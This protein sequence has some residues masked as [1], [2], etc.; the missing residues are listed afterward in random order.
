MEAA[1]PS[2][3]ANP[4]TLMA[5]LTVDQMKTL[6]EQWEEIA[7]RRDVRRWRAAHGAAIAAAT[8]GARHFQNYPAG[9]AAESTLAEHGDGEGDHSNSG[10][11]VPNPH[12]A[13]APAP[14]KSTSSPTA[15]GV[16]ADRSPSLRTDQKTVSG[17]HL[18]SLMSFRAL[19]RLDPGPESPFALRTASYGEGGNSTGDR[20]KVF[21]SSFRIPRSTFLRLLAPPLRERFSES[22]LPLAKLRQMLRA[23]FRT[24][25]AESCGQI[26]WDTL[27][28]YL[29]DTEAAAGI[30]SGKETTVSSAVL[31]RRRR[32]GSDG[33]I[34][35][36]G[37]PKKKDGIFD[38][39]SDESGESS[40]AS[41]GA[42]TSDDDEDEEEDEDDEDAALTPSAVLAV[43]EVKW[44]NSSKRSTINFLGGNLDY[45]GKLIALDPNPLVVAVTRL[46]SLYFLDTTDSKFTALKS[47]KLPGPP[48]AWVYVHN[49]AMAMSVPGLFAVRSFFVITT[50]NL[51]MCLFP[52]FGLDSTD[53]G[54]KLRTVVQNHELVSALEWGRHDNLLYGGTRSGDLLVWN[55]TPKGAIIP[56]RRFGLHSD[57]ITKL[58]CTTGY[59][60]ISCS[61][62]QTIQE[63]SLGRIPQLAT[64][65]QSSTIKGST[66]DGSTGAVG[67][68]SVD[69][70]DTFDT[71]L[72]ITFRRH[73]FHA[74]SSV[75]KVLHA[76][77]HVLIIALCSDG[78]ILGY[79]ESFPTVPAYQLLPP[80]G[81]GA[82][83]TPVLNIH[84][85]ES[86]D[87]LFAVDKLATLRVWDLKTT[88]IIFQGPLIPTNKA[89]ANAVSCVELCLASCQ[90]LINTAGDM[91]VT[92]FR[93]SETDTTTSG[94]VR[95]ILDSTE[96]AAF[97][98]QAHP[99]K[100]FCTVIF[101][102]GGVATWDTEHHRR[103]SFIEKPFPQVSAGALEPAGNRLILGGT[104]GELAVFRA[105][106]GRLI[107][108]Y[109]TPKDCGEITAIT[110]VNVLHGLGDLMNVDAGNDSD[111]G[112]GDE[113]PN[114]VESGNPS[115]A[116]THHG[117]SSH[118]S[119]HPDQIIA[120]TESGLLLVCLDGEDSAGSDGQQGASAGGVSSGS[121]SA[122]AGSHLPIQP[123]RVIRLP[124]GITL[125]RIFNVGLGTNLFAGIDAKTMKWVSF[126]FDGV[127][128]HAVRLRPTP[129]QTG[130]AP[131]ATSSD[132]PSSPAAPAGQ[133]KSKPGIEP[134]EQ[135][136]TCICVLSPY[137][138]VAVGSSDGSISIFG[139]RPHLLG[140]RVLCTFL[141]AAGA[142]PP[143][144]NAAESKLVQASVAKPMVPSFGTAQRQSTAAQQEPDMLTGTADRSS[145][146]RTAAEMAFIYPYGL[147]TVD[148]RNRVTLWDISDVVLQCRLMDVRK[149]TAPGLFGGAGRQGGGRS[150]SIAD[151]SL[152][153]ALGL[154]KAM[155]KLG[156][157]VRRPQHRVSMQRPSVASRSVTSPISGASQLSHG[158]THLSDSTHSHKAPPGSISQQREYSEYVKAHSLLFH[159]VQRPPIV[160]AVNVI[161]LPLG[162]ACI[163]AVCFQAPNI[164]TCVTESGAVCLL[165][166]LPPS[167]SAKVVVPSASD[168]VPVDSTGE[169]V[170]NPG[171][172]VLS[173][174]S[175]FGK[176][177]N[178][179]ELKELAPTTAP[180]HAVQ[181]PSSLASKRRTMVRLGRLSSTATPY[182]RIWRR[183]CHL[184]RVCWLL[185]KCLGAAKNKLHSFDS[186]VEA[187][188]HRRNL[189]SGAFG[190]FPYSTS[191][192]L[193]FPVL[194]PK[195]TD[196]RAG[197][198]DEKGLVPRRTPPPPLASNGVGADMAAASPAGGIP[199]GPSKVRIPDFPS[200]PSQM[201]FLSLTL[202]GALDTCRA[203]DDDPPEGVI[204]S[205][206]RGNSSFAFDSRR[207]SSVTF[208]F[209]P[210]QPL[211]L[212]PSVAF[213]PLSL[214]HSSDDPLHVDNDAADAPTR[215]EPAQATAFGVNSVRHGA[216]QT[217]RGKDF[218]KVS[219][220]MFD[221]SELQSVNRLQLQNLKVLHQAVQHFNAP[222]VAETPPEPKPAL[223]VQEELMREREVRLKGRPGSAGTRSSF[224]A[225]VAAASPS[226]RPETPQSL[227][228]EP[229]SNGLLLVHK[230][231]PV[232]KSPSDEGLHPIFQ[233][234]CNL[235]APRSQHI[236]SHETSTTLTKPVFNTSLKSTCDRLLRQYIA[237]D[238]AL[239]KEEEAV[240]TETPKCPPN[241]LAPSTAGAVSSSSPSSPGASP[242]PTSAVEG[243]LS[244]RSDGPLG[245]FPE[246]SR[247]LDQSA[248]HLSAATG[249]AAAEAGSDKS[250][251]QVQIQ[252]SPRAFLHGKHHSFRI[253]KKVGSEPP[254]S[255]PT[256]SVDPSQQKG[257]EEAG[258]NDAQDHEHPL[259]R[260]SDGTPRSSRKKL[261]SFG[262]LDP[263]RSANSSRY[264]LLGVDWEDSI[265]FD[266]PDASPSPAFSDVR[267]VEEGAD[268][269]QIL[270]RLRE[271]GGDRSGRGTDGGQERREANEKSNIDP[272][273]W[274][275]RDE[276][277]E[278]RG[279]S[280]APE[281]RERTPLSRPP[282]PQSAPLRKPPVSQPN[283]LPSPSTPAAS[284]DPKPANLQ[285]IQPPPTFVH[286]RSQTRAPPNVESLTLPSYN[287]SELTTGTGSSPGRY[288]RSGR[289]VSIVHQSGPS[290]LN[291]LS[292]SGL[293][294]STV[295]NR[296]RPSSAIPLRRSLAEVEREKA[297]RDSGSTPAFDLAKVGGAFFP[298]GSTS[299]AGPHAGGGQVSQGGQAEKLRLFAAVEEYEKSR[300]PSLLQR[301][302][303]TSALQKTVLTTDQRKS[304]PQIKYRYV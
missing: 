44:E 114:P 219:F 236:I 152:G 142:P 302:I 29:I 169:Q 123:H 90:I 33:E 81:A 14:S 50:N 159:Q 125:R 138:A 83:A 150:M 52:I 11:V 140:D 199:T 277:A 4:R 56:K 58:I 133:K 165:T 216:M 139:T 228:G 6:K 200:H 32:I 23:L 145:L 1:D 264:R 191:T 92:R 157:S 2:Y 54:M 128:D 261:Q 100:S 62:D 276:A 19:H 175:Q 251:F 132:D 51:K 242:R 183:A 13:P 257:S 127:S 15:G 86:K 267:F 102:S 42:D 156:A 297:K 227:P 135:T 214:Q 295:S 68:A 124:S 18:L 217:D 171:G 274:L 211:S 57:T 255:P 59:R 269:D 231:D 38:E 304:V 146:R 37:R 249:A 234:V 187:Q 101:S 9:E 106:T 89:R 22:L 121:A 112:E 245:D 248:K 287:A 131:K 108:R 252:F 147:V 212:A 116:T 69:P 104:L 87:H 36:K 177:K 259:N 193:V 158:K 94:A 189:A 172:L 27:T 174:F 130:V 7:Q 215:P 17:K 73:V 88:A 198:R 176:K 168:A 205:Q 243:Q 207:G 256:P 288:C 221:E 85:D 91:S 98:A 289:D 77:K 275:V 268:D 31:R 204:E 49:R 21:A 71:K 244:H 247:R 25:D 143:T 111:G 46:G 113:K 209:E 153:A 80:S 141:L 233:A 206:Q 281:L 196:D 292:S 270:D 161:D 224:T 126:Q 3:L 202:A 238:E 265:I 61:T 65:V 226:R 96:A 285:P 93:Y 190:R 254:A 263:T 41:D 301:T 260:S 298:A 134:F 144:T 107:R 82:N 164:I 154:S 148:D 47:H 290:E 184:V 272:R 208:S 266:R 35:T 197:T 30:D 53:R 166:I 155:R 284:H 28:E 182:L 240:F 20:Q 105:D 283:G 181:G 250:D 110:Y 167:F 195:G 95:S 218:R 55:V 163:S 235:G 66:L 99:K 299:S 43:T 34:L 40:D 280:A 253:A 178:E 241:S 192:A 222:S 237:E 293:N 48:S 5:A 194:Q 185:T 119:K 300:K 136:I 229:I 75:L 273:L 39:G 225:T 294:G 120:T 74:P 291:K 223:F 103:R 286:C 72:S 76:P 45:V 271:E 109:A 160:R 282:R 79:I 188:L 151:R 26:S 129:T 278:P 173:D 203:N 115:T 84:L 60:L 201:A 213:S 12:P 10:V 179:S 279:M 16:G 170:V 137:P 149:I 97:T 210:Y 67:E 162:D 70:L 220:E 63:T 117:S 230:L 258:R 246:S 78:G 232:H 64:A 118:S 239:R 24:L 180:S 186:F 296:P 262:K 303:E 8:R 122:Q